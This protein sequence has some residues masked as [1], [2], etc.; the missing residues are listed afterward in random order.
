MKFDEFVSCRTCK[1]YNVLW[2]NPPCSE[3]SEL[4][5]G[6]EYELKYEKRKE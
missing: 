2:F 4:N 3:C 6:E 1:H 5:Y